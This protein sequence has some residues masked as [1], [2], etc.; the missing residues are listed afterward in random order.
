MR[1]GVVT[2]CDAGKRGCTLLLNTLVSMDYDP[3][4]LHWNT[5]NLISLIRRSGIK[6]WIFSGNATYTKDTDMYRMPME[7]FSLPI[8]IL[9]ICYSFQ[10]TLVQLGYTLHHKRKRQY[11]KVAI[12]LPSGKP[13]TIL[14]NYTQFIRSPVIG[15]VA[16]FEKEVMIF[17]YKNALLTQFHPEGTADGRKLMR[18]FLE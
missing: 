13:M 16:S 15:E 8:H 4:V 9:C 10:S 7:A 5:P 12:Q 1:V 14:L 11:R 6:H 18:A 3:F 17:I 2:M